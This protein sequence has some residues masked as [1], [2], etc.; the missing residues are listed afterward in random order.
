MEIIIGKA[1]GEIGGS[2]DLFYRIY[3]QCFECDNINFTKKTV[4]WEKET[5]IFQ[6]NDKVLGNIWIADA[7]NIEPIKDETYEF[8]LSSNNLEH[9]A[10][11]IKALKESFRILKKVELS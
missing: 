5:D 11:P 7:T 10:N 9:I 1:G 8:V 3:S 2:T 4:W 6:Y